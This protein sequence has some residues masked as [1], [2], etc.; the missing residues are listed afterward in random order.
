MNND[1][2][3]TQFGEPVIF[4]VLEND[5]F[6]AAYFLDTIFSSDNGSAVINGDATVSYVP[7]NTFAG[8][9]QLTYRVCS[10]TCPDV[11]ATATVGVDVLVNRDVE[12]IVLPNT[13]TPNG[14]GMNDAL[15]IPEILE[16]PG[17]ELII[18]NRWGDE[19]YRTPD[20][21]NDWD[22]FWQENSELLPVGTYFYIVN[23]NDSNRTRLSG[24]VY[25][26]RD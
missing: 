10:N 5:S 1:N 8:T 22:G 14:D 17:S 13:I 2:F 20:Y 23:L 9:D 15:I 24:Y 4:N 18:F 12:K 7:V 16:Y 3:N 21:K 25:I 19:V 6:S 11:C 26:Q